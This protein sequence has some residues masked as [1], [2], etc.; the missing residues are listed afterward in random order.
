MKAVSSDT[1]K[2]IFTSFH[3]PMFYNSAR[4]T[5]PSTKSDFESVIHI[6][7]L[8]LTFL[9]TFL[10]VFLLNIFVTPFT[11]SSR[12][13]HLYIW[14]LWLLRSPVSTSL[15][16]Q[17]FKYCLLNIAERRCC[18]SI[19]SYVN[20]ECSKASVQLCLTCHT[21]AAYNRCSMQNNSSI[22]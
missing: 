11:Q 7:N 14:F 2:F 17:I 10:L 9:S 22:V 6:S 5:P 13:T 16:S 19:L 8:Q 4:K 1:N 21:L 18:R 3:V 20:I 12:C 15:S